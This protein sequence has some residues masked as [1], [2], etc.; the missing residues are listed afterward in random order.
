MSFFEGKNDEVAVVPDAQPYTLD[1][2]VPGADDDLNDAIRNASALVRD[3]ERPP[4]GAAGLIARARGDYAR[5]LA[6]L[7]ATGRYGGT[8]EILVGGQPVET[9]RPDIELPDPVDV[10]VTVDPGPVFAFGSVRVDGLPDTQMTEEDE[11][12]LQLDDWT[13]IRGDDA[14][15]GAILDAEGKIVEV[16]RQRGHPTA[17]VP[18]REI[19]ADHATNTVDVVLVVEP[20]PA[21][22]LG[23]LEITGTDRM[24]PEFVRW[25]T[26]IKP[27]EPYDPDTLR[28]ARERLQRLGAFSSVAI[29]EAELVGADGILPVTFNLSERKRRVFGGGASYSTLEGATLEAYW[30]HRNL[31][32][33]AES[34]RFDASVSRIGASDLGGLNYALATTFKRPG[35]FTPDTDLTL[36]LSGKREIVDA[37][38]SDTIAAKAGL[39][40]TFSDTLKA[41]TALNVEYASIDDAFGQNEYFIV[42]LPSRLD[43]DGRDNKLEP[44]EGLRA[45]LDLEPLVELQG[46]TIALVSRGSL[47]GYR[48][49]GDDDRL[50]LAARGALGSIIGGEGGDIPATRRFFLGGGGSIR[51]YEYRSVGPR[52]GDEVVG[53]L[54]FFEAS[55]EARFRL[56]DTIGIV[57]FIDAGAA[58]EDTIPNFRREREAR[59]GRRPAVLYGARSASPRCRRAAQSGRR[60]SELRLLCRPGTVVLMRKMP[61]L[62]VVLAIAAAAFGVALAQ[63]QQTDSTRL[64]RLLEG[65]LSTPERQVSFRGLSGVFTSSPTVETITV[66][67][68]DGVWLRIEGVE[69][70]WSRTALIRRILDI[71]SLTARQITMLRKPAP[72]AGEVEGGSPAGAPPVDI[73]VD[74]F[75]L[76]SI[77]LDAPVIGAAAQL[78]AEG[79]LRVTE[80]VLAARIAVLRHDREGRLSAD[81]RLEPEGNVL[82]ANV[83]LAEPEGGILAETFGLRGSPALTLTLAGSGPLAQWQ[84]DID[85]QANGA[86][87]LSGL[88]AVTR[89]DAGYRIAGELAAALETIVPQTYASLFAGEGRLSLNVVRRDDGGLAIENAALRS[90][91]VDLSATGELTPDFVPASA[92]ISLQLGAAG[93]TMLPLVPGEVS[94]MGLTATI[95][96]DDGAVA[97]W[98]ADIQAQDVESAFGAVGSVSLAASGQGERLTDPASRSVTFSLEA[99]AE[100]VAPVDAALAAAIGP[101]LRLTGKGAWAAGQPVNLESLQAVLTGATATFAGTASAAELNGRFTAGATDLQR[102]SAIAGRPLGGSAQLQAE[103]TVRP[104]DA[105]FDLQLAGEGTDLELGV[106]ALGPM[107]AGTTRLEGGVA[108]NG[109]AITFDDLALSNDAIAARVSGDVAGADLDLAVAASVVDLSSLSERATGGATIEAT[110]TGTTAAPEI[111]AEVNGDEIVLMGR[112]LEDAMARFSGVVA[113]PEVSGDAEIGG[114]LDGVPVMGSARLSSAE[115]GGRA[116]NELLFS[117]G[118]S[119]VSGNLI[120]GG[121]GL[122]TGDIALVSPDLSQVAP[123]FLVEASG[124]VRA[125]I[126][127]SAEGGQQAASIN[128]SAADLVYETISIDTA[129]ISGEARDLFGV[130]QIDGNFNVRNLTAGGLTVVSATGTAQRQGQATGFDADAELADGRAALAG[131]LE[132]RGA[133]LALSLANLSFTRNGLNAAL[134]SPT[135]ILIENGTARFNNT[136]LNVGGGNVTLN[137][138]A[139]STLNLSVD[140]SAHAGVADQ[141]LRARSRGGGHHIRHGDGDRVGVC[142]ERPLQRQLGRRIAQCLAQCRARC[143]RRLGR[144]HAQQRHRLAERPRHRKRRP[145]DPGHRHGGDH[146]G[147]R[148]Q[149]Q[150]QRCSA[151]V[152]RQP[153]PGE[154][155]RGAAGRIAARH[156]GDRHDDIASVLGPRHFGGGRLRRS[157]KRYRAFGPV[158]GGRRLQQRHRHPAA[159]GAE[160]RGECLGERLDRARPGHRLPRRPRGRRAARALRR[161]HAG[162]RDRR[163]RH[164]D[165]R[166]FQRRADD[167]RQRADPRGR[168]H[169]ARAAA[170]RLCCRRRRAC[171]YAAGRAARHSS[172]RARRAAAPAAAVPAASASTSRSTRRAAFSSGAVASTRRWAGHFA[173]PAPRRR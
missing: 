83:Q 110:I 4:P 42:S 130:P 93:R 75:S 158:T 159:H 165:H 121:D 61:R 155:G 150:D 26:G 126:A 17:S 56:T 36:Q 133:G 95:G 13:M 78:S 16:W 71:D 3:E 134:A 14:R 25:M 171:P 20:G 53:G 123:L 40:H 127:L 140:V 97:P 87:V 166:Q 142:A 168:G 74:G 9:M 138:A 76:P 82:T 72:A 90:Q 31:F 131:N 122:L 144:R 85:M 27:G 160:R 44:T 47:S 167:R 86:S 15:S 67:D 161:R 23:T 98:R 157:G 69:A 156:R 101:T 32:G 34:L 119:R 49:F 169:G 120:I 117:V 43:Y 113:G 124:M 62:L 8:I 116:L 7:Y 162:R 104:P 89:L 68:A 45:T 108:R 173:S 128:G 149:S 81:L 51:G 50:V 132:P 164:H 6:A 143:A 84:A 12:A 137:G 64:E 48:G 54:S 100:A 22:Q 146:G 30:A 35:V 65:M 94:V 172:G 2:T 5:L 66:A 37:Y 88:V 60:R 99:N 46:S 141:R 57:P 163:R 73:I 1:F 55:L 170:A 28:K 102:F 135:T 118:E 154:P 19:V 109:D 52:I 115:G 106:A 151:A 79:E 10:K 11:D 21:A 139:G 58:Y 136:R 105:G 24:D 38:E 39:E 153:Q 145:R 70:V 148:T 147:R 77:T 125:D 103:G 33:H 41:S 112:P 111:D 107:L 92:D 29:A 59:R 91:G 63:D 18:T 129:D 114:S 80:E 96:L 152:A